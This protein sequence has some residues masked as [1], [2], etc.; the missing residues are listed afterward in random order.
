V[1]ELVYLL[2]ARYSRVARLAIRHSCLLPST[3]SF[4]LSSITDWPPPA[5]QQGG[6]GSTGGD[7]DDFI[8]DSLL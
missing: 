3:S 6:N 7:D 1:G 4:I 2:R 8:L 5:L